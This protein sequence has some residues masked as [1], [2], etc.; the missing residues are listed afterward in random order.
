[1][2]RF[3]FGWI[4]ISCTDHVTHSREPHLLSIQLAPRS[5]GPNLVGIQAGVLGSAFGKLSEAVAK[6]PAVLNHAPSKPSS[7]RFAMLFL[8]Q[9]FHLVAGGISTLSREA[10]TM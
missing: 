5:G 3:Q 9:H 1:M 6:R 7:S 8:C 2:R 10:V 4:R